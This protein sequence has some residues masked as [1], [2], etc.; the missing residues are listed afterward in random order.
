MTAR[1]ANTTLLRAMGVSAG[2]ITAATVRMRPGQYPQLVLTQIITSKQLA[3]GGLHEEQARFRLVPETSPPQR[4]PFDLDALCAQ[5]R[6]DLAHDIGLNAAIAAME[7]AKGFRLLRKNVQRKRSLR[8][9][10]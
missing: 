2:N 5:A 4:A 10:V 6:A 1:D 8:G 3:C 9:A 7:V